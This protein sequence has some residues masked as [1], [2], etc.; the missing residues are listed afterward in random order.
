[1][2]ALRDT[3]GDGVTDYDELELYGTDPDT[4]FSGGDVLS[5]GE[6]ILLG[7]D[8]RSR[9]AEGVLLQS[10]RTFASE[11]PDSYR[12]ERV[13]TRPSALG[14]S[15]RIVIE[16]VTDPLLFITVY[17]YPEQR[18]L[19][20]RADAQ[21]RFSAVFE[22]MFPPGVYE[23]YVGTTNAAGALVAH[24]GAVPLMVGTSTVELLHL[25]STSTALTD[26][27]IPLRTLLTLIGFGLIMG[28]GGLLVW[29]GHRPTLPTTQ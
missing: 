5:D 25:T 11:T 16:G 18:V 14:T 10:P 20:V 1:M 2:V 26:Q 29:A 8:P 3:D 24:G 21:G 23:L 28:V 17:L 6:R 27:G 15:K 19:T 12:I 9:E 13:T 7:L 4:P 22:G